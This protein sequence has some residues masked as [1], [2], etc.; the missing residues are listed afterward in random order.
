MQGGG[1]ACA[2]QHL[3]PP[4]PVDSS[5]V[6]DIQHFSVKNDKQRC[7]SGVETGDGELMFPMIVGRWNTGTEKTEDRSCSAGYAHE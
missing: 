5:G 1:S 6:C 2:K 7:R 3:T 4:N